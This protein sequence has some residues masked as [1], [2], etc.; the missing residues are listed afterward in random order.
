MKHLRRLALAATFGC[1]SVTIPLMSATAL[2][3]DV[4]PTEPVPVET[5][6]EQFGSAYI[7]ARILGAWSDDTEFGLDTAATVPTDIENGYE[8]FGVSG[9][10][11]VGYSFGNG[12]RLE[13]EGSYTEQDVDSHTVT[14][15]GATFSGGNAFGTTSVTQG[16]VN[17]YYDFDLG[18]FKPYVT[19]GI[20]FAHVDFDNHGIFLAA[21][22]AGLPAGD[23]VAMNDDDT[24]FAFQVGIGTSYALTENVDL[25]LGYRYTGITSVD[26][27][28]VD[29]TSTDVDLS[30]HSVLAGVRYS[31]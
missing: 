6:S 26:L 5:E 13:V 16:L 15:L 14:A 21:P 28:A 2:A 10:L 4:I 12:F 7:A 25:E 18:A 20:G 23:V 1:C 11:A 9:A 31:F 3:A 8:D 17:A 30:Y 24:G 27:Q 29:G 19:G 22:T